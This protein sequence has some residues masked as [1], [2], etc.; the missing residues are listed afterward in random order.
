MAVARG[1]GQ[2]HRVDT[3]W[4]LA[5]VIGPLLIAA[6]ASWLPTWHM[7]ASAEM[8]AHAHGQSISAGSGLHSLGTAH[9]DRT[10]GDQTSE[11]PTHAHLGYACLCCSVL[12]G[13][14]QLFLRPTAF[15][16]A[17]SLVETGSQL[18]HTVAPESPPPQV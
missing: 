11:G 14:T 10:H 13:D 15:I 5:L 12:C 2:A 7:P 6:L 3:P 1:P 16:T 9:H 4:L 8:T 18:S 17:T